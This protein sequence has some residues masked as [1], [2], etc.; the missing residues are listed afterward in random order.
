M[1]NCLLRSIEFFRKTALKIIK[2]EGNQT[3]PIL[4]SK[5]FWVIA[6]WGRWHNFIYVCIC[7][8]S[9]FCICLMAD[10]FFS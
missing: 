7:I 2:I 6:I 9:H 1:R 3:C 10:F 5:Y 4:G 8:Y